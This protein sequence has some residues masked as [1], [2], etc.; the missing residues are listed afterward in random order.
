[1]ATTIAF[2]GEKYRLDINGQLTDG[3]TGGHGM[4]EKKIPDDCPEGKLPVWFAN[5]T[6]RPRRQLESENGT[7]R[8]GALVPRFAV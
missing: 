4:I 2:A 7:R 6:A 1:M 3:T 5:D 8:I